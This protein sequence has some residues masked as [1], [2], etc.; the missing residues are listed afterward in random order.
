MLNCDA[1]RRA[2]YGPQVG[3]LKADVATPPPKTGLPSSIHLG[4]HKLGGMESTKRIKGA[5][6]DT[7][8]LAQRLPV[9]CRLLIAASKVTILP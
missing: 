5:I 8:D 9:D 7:S 6:R 3:L 1:A 2:L 4:L